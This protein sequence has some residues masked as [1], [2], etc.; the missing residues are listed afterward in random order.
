MLNI[1]NQ[2]AIE[3]GSGS[4]TLDSLFPDYVVFRPDPGRPLLH[5]ACADGQHYLP[6]DLLRC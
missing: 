6:A 3:Y 5:P 1:Q 4:E 2:K